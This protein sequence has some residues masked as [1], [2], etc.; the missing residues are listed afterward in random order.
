GRKEHPKDTVFPA[1]RSMSMGMSR[2]S[3]RFILGGMGKI[4][5]GRVLFNTM[6]IVLCTATCFGHGGA[7]YFTD[8]G[9]QGVSRAKLKRIFRNLVACFPM[10]VF[11]DLNGILGTA[12]AVALDH[13]VHAFP[14]ELFRQI[15]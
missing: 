2:V 3:L 8:I 1:G 14:K 7:F 9:R 13:K 15:N 10:L 11:G 12:V 4:F 5:P 6:D